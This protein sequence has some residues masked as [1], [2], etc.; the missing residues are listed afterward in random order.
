MATQ[1]H[2][3]KGRGFDQS[4]IY[5]EHKNDYWS[6]SIMQSECLS[7]GDGE[8]ARLLDLWEDDG[9]AEVTDEYEGTTFQV[10][11]DF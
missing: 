10:R 6:K 9:P 8:Y 1:D 5:F 4:L 11:A 3:P 2:T 7:A